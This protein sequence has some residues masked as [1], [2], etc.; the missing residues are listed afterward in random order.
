MIPFPHDP[1][2]GVQIA[3]LFYSQLIV[4]YLIASRKK[5]ERVVYVY[6]A[7][8]KILWTVARVIFGCMPTQSIFQ[9]FLIVPF[10]IWDLQCQHLDITVSTFEH[11]MLNIYVRIDK[12]PPRNIYLSTYFLR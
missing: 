2:R 12:Y 7:L 6:S 4:R 3:P 9:F 5:S 10:N 11:E 1:A 8:V